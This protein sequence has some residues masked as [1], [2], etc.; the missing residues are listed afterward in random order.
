MSPRPK[1]LQSNSQHEPSQHCVWILRKNSGINDESCIVNHQSDSVFHKKAGYVGSPSRR[2]ALPVWI[3][4]S[5]T[6]FWLTSRTSISIEFTTEIKWK[7]SQ[8]NPI[9]LLLPS[10]RSSLT[11]CMTLWGTLVL[12]LMA[13]LMMSVTTRV[14]RRGYSGSS[15]QMIVPKLHAA[16]RTVWRGRIVSTARSHARLMYKTR[17][18]FRA[19]R[20]TATHKPQE[21]V[22]IKPNNPLIVCQQ[23]Q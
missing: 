4:R 9:L 7:P 23:Q 19:I 13:L 6:T 18:W 16:R 17:L 11:L 21:K 8:P 20:I 15:L 14:M 22:Q 10:P 1:T 2:T 3:M 12:I 5:S